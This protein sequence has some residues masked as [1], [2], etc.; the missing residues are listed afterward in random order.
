MRAG[1]AAPE[2]QHGESE[3]LGKN[4]ESATCN[5]CLGYKPGRDD[6]EMTQCH[7]ACGQ[8]LPDYHFVDDMLQAWR[9]KNALAEAKCARCVA[10]ERKDADEV[11]GACSNPTCGKPRCLWEFQAAEVKDVLKNFRQTPRKKCYE[12]SHPPCAKC[13]KDK[14][15]ENRP[16]DAIKGISELVKEEYLCPDHKYP[17]CM[18]CGAKRTESESQRCSRE[19]LL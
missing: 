18:F 15:I 1:A 6:R 5:E 16:V 4:C 2:F 3:S 7:G 17:P 11:I 12:C 14:G 19:I 9:S 8:K 10:R 13:L